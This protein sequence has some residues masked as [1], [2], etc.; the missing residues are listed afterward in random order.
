MPVIARALAG[1]I[2]GWWTGQ[3]VAQN[4]PSRTIENQQLIWYGWFIKIP[5]DSVR[6]FSTDIQ[7]RHFVGPAAQHQ[8][9]L[10]GQLNRHWTSHFS[11]AL[12]FCLFFQSPNDPEVSPRLMVPELR[13]HVEAH[14]SQKFS[15]LQIDHRLRTEA[16]FFRHLTPDGTALAEGYSFRNFRFRYQMAFSFPII[17]R[18]NGFTAS[19]RL[20][21]ELHLQT[22]APGFLWFDQNRFYAGLRFAPTSRLAFDIG[23]MNWYQFTRNGSLIFDRDILRFTVNQ[24]LG[25]RKA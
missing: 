23:Y 14:L 20:T 9:V 6:T 21:D 17:K 10:R 19:L 8:L 11:T 16:R 1:L 12:G 22:P 24:Q 2:I 5:V 4:N 3:L 7:E 13:P 25:T 18:T 15:R